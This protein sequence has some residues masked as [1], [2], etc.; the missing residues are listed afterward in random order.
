MLA[1][2]VAALASAGW[3]AARLA[4]T[5]TK[6]LSFQLPN[7]AQRILFLGYGGGDHPG[8]YLSD[9]IVLMVRDG[10]KQAEISIPRDLWV[11]IPPGSGRYARINEALQDGYNSG[12]LDA[13]AELAAR[14]VAEVTGL[15]VTGWVLQDF[16]GF[17]QLV[18]A[19]GGVDVDVPRSFSAQYPV[20]DNP[21]VDARWRVVH[22]DAGRQHMNGERALEFARAR[23]ADVP[24]EASDFARAARQQLLVRAIKAKMAS[25]WGAI[26]LV[27]LANAA[28]D[29]VHTN[30]SPV[31]LAAF[32]G[33]FHPEQARRISLDSVV[34][35]GRAP[36]GS[37]ILLPRN[38]SYAGIADYVKSQL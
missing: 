14:K 22:F 16:H 32:V 29:G 2:V 31:E 37:Q 7:G 18:D 10:P 20:N 26:C 24:Q 3:S 1:L 8:A 12:G 19:L 4:G 21:V 11:Q 27:P 6:P 23:Y 25:P 35:D 33:G 36:D 15:T 5:S 34:V 30:L 13:G 38:G 17:R 28:A 9:S